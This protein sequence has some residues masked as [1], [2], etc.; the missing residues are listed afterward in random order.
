VETYR[1]DGLL[2]SIARMSGETLTLTYS[3]GAFGGVFVHR[4][5]TPTGEALTANL[6]LRVTDS[7]GNALS[8][9]YSAPGKLVAMFDPS[10]GRTFYTYDLFRPYDNVNPV[11]LN[12]NLA[13]VTYPDGHTRS[14]RYTEQ[15]N[16]PST[17]GSNAFPHAL[18][19][20]V[21]ENGAVFAS[22][23]YDISA[24]I[25]STE[26]SG[27]AGAISSATTGPAHPPS[28]LP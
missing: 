7:Y 10:G 8:F 28:E 23:K 11:G 20:I 21:D 25:L 2:Q 18:T 16:L 27:G 15:A 5:G 6:L 26:H 1:A 19:S 22:F 24:R 9:D 3:G 14:Y 12:N 13:S 4:D 17:I